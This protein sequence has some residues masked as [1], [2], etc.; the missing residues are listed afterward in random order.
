MSAIYGEVPEPRIIGSRQERSGVTVLT[1]AIPMVLKTIG[2][3]LKYPA[4][5]EI[6]QIP[7]YGFTGGVG[8]EAAG[9]YWEWELT[10]E[11]GRKLTPEGEKAEEDQAVYTLDTSDAEVPITS[12]PD[13]LKLKE[14]YK[15]DV[16]EG[17]I[18]FQEEL[19]VEDSDTG[20]KKNPMFKVE[21]YLSFGAIWSKQYVTKTLPSELFDGIE[22]VVAQIPQ[23]RS[24]KIPKLGRGRNWLKRVP[25]VRV[26][27]S[28]FEITERY[29]LSGRGGWNTDVYKREGMG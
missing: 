22:S 21:S 24:V 3:S 2:D 26:R 15:G 10:Y 5:L 4:P 6:P 13:W 17:I 7:G 23:P 18:E 8:K 19:P 14:K 25:S 20:S 29:L 28:V 11:G 9:G 27:G 12:H 1:I 16:K